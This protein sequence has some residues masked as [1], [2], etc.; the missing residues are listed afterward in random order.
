LLKQRYDLFRPVR[1]VF[2]DHNP[3]K[4]PRRLVGFAV[5]IDRGYKPNGRAVIVSRIGGPPNGKLAAFGYA[6]GDFI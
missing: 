4:R 2:R 3:H 5:F 6:F 1:R